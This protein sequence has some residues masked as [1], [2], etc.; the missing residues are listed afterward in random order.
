MKISDAVRR[1]HNRAI[2]IRPQHPP[3]FPHQSGIRATRTR[4]FREVSSAFFIATVPQPTRNAPC[5][6]ARA[7]RRAAKSSAILPM[8]IGLPRIDVRQRDCFEAGH[9]ALV[10]IWEERMATTEKSFIVILRLL[11][12]WTFLYAASHQVL[13][14]G[15]SVA[16]FLSKTKTFHDLFAMFTGPTVAPIVTFL[17]GYGHL[18]IGLSLLV[19]LMVRVSASFGI[20]LLLMYWLAHMDF[21]YIENPNN[22]IVDYHIVYATVLGYLIH[23]HA[24]HVWGLDAL[25]SRIPSFREGE[26]L[27]PLVA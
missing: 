7:R 22:L 17:V 5:S 12:A 4:N 25:A 15:W 16:G 21:P 11:M 10:E 6:S 26:A 20:L 9:D 2:R 8:Y 14:P 27:H 19:G 3:S 18:L 24:G 13:V 23:K 1:S